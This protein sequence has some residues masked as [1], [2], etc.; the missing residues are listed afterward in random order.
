MEQS[1]T[2]LFLIKK[3][4]SIL[5]AAVVVEAACCLVSFTDSLISGNML[6]PEALSAVALVSPFMSVGTF[7]TCVINS[8]TLLDYSYNVGK[9][10]TDRS[11]KIFCQGVLTAAV[12]GTILFLTLLLCKDLFLQS[13]GYSD[14][15]AGYANDYY[16]II[17]FYLWLCPLTCVL[18]NVM[19][20][21]GGESVSAA[22]NTTEIVGN[23]VL[24]I[25]FA[26]LWGIKGLAAASVICKLIFLAITLIWY[27]RHS[28]LRLFLFFKMAPFLRM[29][30]N[31]V[32]KASTFA[33]SGLMYMI[34]NEMYL[35]QFGE[36]TFTLLAVAERFMGLSSLF[37]GLA[38]AM[39]PLGSM[40]R[41][42]NNAWGQRRLMR[43]VTA[44]MSR[45]GLISS[46]LTIILAPFLIRV[47]GIRDSSLVAEGTLVLRLIGLSLV[48][49]SVSCMLYI[50]YYLAEHLV[51]CLTVSALKDLV[52]PV[53]C[54]FIG[55][56]LLKS[57]LSLWL[58]FD[59]S[60][61][62][63]VVFALLIVFLKYGRKNW[64]WLLSPAEEIGMFCY[65]FEI[66][67]ENAVEMSKTMM[68]LISETA[69][70]SEP[71]HAR[72]RV[73]ELAGLFTED[74][75]MAVKEK[76][77]D[78]K[79]L[80]AEVMVILDDDGIR[81]ILR[82]SGTLFDITEDDS[83]VSAFRDYIISRVVTLS[84]YKTYTIATG[85]NRNEIFIGYE[86]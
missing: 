65:D 15:M 6:G 20:C 66:T 47:F 45:F 74:L 68:Q 62:L 48:F 38:G 53:F 59:L 42:E 1:I 29:F 26:R 37:L 34:L 5:R 28:H 52:L 85:Y 80:D 56:R 10:D 27:I 83:K 79:T 11:N 22:A 2:P 60:Q 70:I 32:V 40:L 17:I 54:A 86:K 69:L 39:Q 3:Y 78:E 30:K 58:L 7:I 21:D 63:S 77:P 75:L 14:S 72:R 84:E 31:G 71:E 81:L 73:M 46:L 50:Y 55:I 49:V 18:D 57:P 82:D 25:L 12:A 8:G 51:L 24:S 44:A 41:G 35:S 67:E 23:V 19:V 36:E 9:G 61:V 33:F 16:T 13:I 64:P 76:N 43:A 4:K